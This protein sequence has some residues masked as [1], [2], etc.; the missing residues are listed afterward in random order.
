MSAS[1]ISSLAAKYGQAY[2]PIEE[3]SHEQFHT[4][5]NAVKGN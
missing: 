4:Q 2:K 5:T 3:G 1:F